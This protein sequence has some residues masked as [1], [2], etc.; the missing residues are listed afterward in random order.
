MPHEAVLQ[1]YHLE[2]HRRPAVTVGPF[3]EKLTS[4]TEHLRVRL[5]KIGRPPGDASGVAGQDGA[6]SVEEGAVPWA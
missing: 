2:R 6:V 5:E 4:G 1:D 3:D